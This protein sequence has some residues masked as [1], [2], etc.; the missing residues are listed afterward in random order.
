[1][2]EDFDLGTLDNGEL[3]RQGHDD[4][5]DGLADEIAQGTVILLSRAWDA[6]EAPR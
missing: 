2:R 6:Q 3:V 5:Y 1:M 4:L